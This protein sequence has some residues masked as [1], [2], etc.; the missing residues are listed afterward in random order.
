M[1]KVGQSIHIKKEVMVEII[2]AFLSDDFEEQARLIPYNMRPKGMEVPYRC[3]VY[4]ERAIIKDRVIAGL[5]FPIEYAKRDAQRE[6]ISDKHLTVL[7]AACKGCK[8]NRVYV[9]NL[10]QGCVAR[11]CQST[12]KFGAISIINGR[13]VIDETK[14]KKCQ[15]CINAC[16]YNAIVKITVPCEDSCPVGAIK[17]DET[18]VGSIDYDKCI[19]CNDCSF[20]CR[21]I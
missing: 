1:N 5:G 3:C 7:Q 15:M 11:P 13:S 9:T 2:K 18:G 8:T 20:N 17:K 19:S 4:K 6:E 14:C 10:C 21:S 12:C 16:P